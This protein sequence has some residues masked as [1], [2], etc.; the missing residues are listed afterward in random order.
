MTREVVMITTHASSTKLRTKVAVF[1]AASAIVTTGTVALAQPASA[2]AYNCSGGY[3][4][5]TK[6][7]GQCRNASRGWGGFRLTVNCYYYAQQTSYGQA[8]RTI[9]ASCPSWS[10]V[11]GIYVVPAAY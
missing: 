6:A 9:S 7:W 2:S 1:A 3:V 5:A 11:T 4:N 10:H 8:P